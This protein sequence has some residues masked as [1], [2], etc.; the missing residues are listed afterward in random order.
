MIYFIT[1]NNNT[2]KH[3]NKIYIYMNYTKNNKMKQD[4]YSLYNVKI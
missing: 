1:H 3:V 2:Y 4:G